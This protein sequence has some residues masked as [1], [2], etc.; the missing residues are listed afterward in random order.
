MLVYEKKVEGTRHLFG[1]LGS[2]P[3]GDDVQLSYLNDNKE[4][5][6]VS[7]SDSY[8][9]AGHGKIKNSEGTII[10]VAIGDTIIIPAGGEMPKSNKC[11]ITL[12]K[13]GDAVGTITGTDIAVEVASGTDVTSLKPTIQI[14]TGAS[15]SPDGTTS[16]DFTNPVTYTV[17]AEDGTTKKVYTV[18]VTVAV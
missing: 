16:K 3:S 4:A 14:S 15:V 18:T 6:E 11:D 9:D 5:V 10:N 17:T 12:F 13:I 1:T 2:V 7:L 8:F